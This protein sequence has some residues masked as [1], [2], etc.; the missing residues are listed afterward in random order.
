MVW[1]GL[2][3]KVIENNISIIVLIIVLAQEQ[4]VEM[5][6]PLRMVAQ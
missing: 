1:H 2:I 5:A 6:Y 3:N 4:W